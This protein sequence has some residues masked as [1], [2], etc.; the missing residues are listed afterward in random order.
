MKTSLPAIVVLSA[1]VILVSS[2]SN[3]KEY[4][5]QRRTAMGDSKNNEKGC[6]I[7]LNDGT[8]NSYATL[9]L[10]TGVYTTPH[11]LADGKTKIFPRD[12]TAYQNKDHF[13]VSAAGF[14]YGGHKSSLA[15]ETLPGFAI[16]IAA[17]KLNVYVKKYLVNHVVIDEFFLQEGSGQVLAYTPE[18][19][20]ALIKNNPE[21]L[22]FFNSNKKHICLSKELKKTA[23]IYNNAY[24]MAS[25]GAK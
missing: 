13:A 8:V 3:S 17:G 5:E 12:I 22:D 24:F 15:I 18:L 4:I 14:S 19:M 11:L 25:S 20:D 9:Q 16:R 23:Y 21:A 2:C 10:V 7:Q 6:F 1:A